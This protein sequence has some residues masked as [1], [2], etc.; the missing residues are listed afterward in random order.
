MSEPT[1][2]VTPEWWPKYLD[3][4]TNAVWW[5]GFYAAV[6]MA[7]RAVSDDEMRAAIRALP[8]SP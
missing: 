4:S 1:A 2:M 8:A 5:R 7:S 3:A 6:E